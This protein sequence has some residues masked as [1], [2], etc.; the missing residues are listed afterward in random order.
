MK[1]SLQSRV[2]DHL[3][4][5]GPQTTGQIAAAVGKFVSATLAKRS[6]ER[7]LQASRKRRLTDKTTPGELAKDPIESGR[8]RCVADAINS[9]YRRKIIKRIAP[10]TYEVD[11]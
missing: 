2:M 8:R 4:A 6:Y 1:N 5:N 11:Q 9:L 3:R 10:A 7:M